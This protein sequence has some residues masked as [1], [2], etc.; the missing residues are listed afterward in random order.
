M[1]MSSPVAPVLH[2]KDE[3]SAERLQALPT[4]RVIMGFAVWMLS[5]HTP[6]MEG[7]QKL[8]QQNLN[9]YPCGSLPA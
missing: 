9:I 3:I 2:G 4:Y 5:L 6:C 8:Q 1:L 7:G